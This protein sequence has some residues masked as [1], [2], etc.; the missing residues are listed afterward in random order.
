MAAYKPCNARTYVVF[1][2]LLL[3]L[4]SQP[5]LLVLVLTLLTDERHTVQLI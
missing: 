3:A 4:G 2:A 5:A 1:A